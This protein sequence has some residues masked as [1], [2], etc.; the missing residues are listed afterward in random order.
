MVKYTKIQSIYK[1]DK[2]THKFTDEFSLL[3]F[4]YL[5]NN[6]WE[7]T[8]KIDGTN[9][10]IKLYP[11]DSINIAGRTDN[12]QFPAHLY[13][14]L[15]EIFINDEMKKKILDTFPYL[16]EKEVEIMKNGVCLYGEGY[17]NKIQKGSKYLGDDCGFILFDIRVANT[18][19]KRQDVY[20]ISRKLG[21]RHV[22]ILGHGTLKDACAM[23]RNGV[24]STFGDFL[25]EGLVL[26]PSVSLRTRNGN[27]VITKIKHRDIESVPQ[28]WREAINRSRILEMKK[29][30]NTVIPDGFEST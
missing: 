30:R 2:K 27:R 13:A 3:E 25:A 26:R 7:F 28:N 15:Q 10:R 16:H 20:E 1:R 24:K 18:W 6:Q 11:D 9:I 23:I 29:E 12:A 14:R 21:I 17:G 5:R 4:W 22:P 8:E 19:L